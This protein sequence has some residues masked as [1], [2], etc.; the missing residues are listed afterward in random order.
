VNYVFPQDVDTE[1]HVA[2]P[3]YQ[4]QGGLTKLELAMCLLAPSVLEQMGAIKPT[5][6]FEANLRT[7]GSA[8]AVLGALAE[9]IL[10]SAEKME[11][12]ADA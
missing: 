12:K 10:I 5:T 11:S 8:C 4:R 9:M 2:V 7:M 6:D 3:R 1:S